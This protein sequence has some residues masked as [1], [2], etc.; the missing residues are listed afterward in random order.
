MLDHLQYVQGSRFS[1]FYR[2]PNLCSHPCSHL[3][4]ALRHQRMGAW[5]CGPKNRVQTGTPAMG[6]VPGV[7]G[8]AV[9]HTVRRGARK[10]GGAAARGGSRGFPS[11]DAARLAQLQRA[12]AALWEGVEERLPAQ[13]VPHDRNRGGGGRW[14]R[15]R[16]LASRKSPC[17]AMQRCRKRQSL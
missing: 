6:M 17:Q 15:G 5:L 7:Q 16:P 13:L 11:L 8:V 14:R 9:V 4:D 12:L 3:D 10:L 2:K 1:A